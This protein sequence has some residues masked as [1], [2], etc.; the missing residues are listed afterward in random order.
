M[1]QITGNTCFIYERHT[2]KPIGYFTQFRFWL[3]SWN[4]YNLKKNTKPAS[5]VMCRAHRWNFRYIFKLKL[6]DR[7]VSAATSDIKLNSNKVY[8]EK[9]IEVKQMFLYWSSQYCWENEETQTFFEYG[10]S[11][12]LI[13]HFSSNYSVAW[14]GYRSLHSP[15][16]SLFRWL[17]VYLKT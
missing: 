3:N 8:V 6:T 10:D 1:K 12:K 9:C 16:R 11:T 7:N 17:L 13:K 15:K 4:T 2:C 5:T 14:K